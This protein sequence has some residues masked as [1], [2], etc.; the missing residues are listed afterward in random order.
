MGFPQLPK[1]LE[2]DGTTR[3][4]I[5]TGQMNRNLRSLDSRFGGL[6][7]QS[8]LASI[9]LL[10]TTPTNGHSYVIEAGTL[11]YTRFAGEWHT[12]PLHEFEIY[13]DIN[14]TSYFYWDGGA[15]NAFTF[16]GE[17]NTGSNLGGGAQVFKSKV[18][19]DL[20]HRTL[21]Q[22]SG[23]TL[24]QSANEIEIAATAGSVNYAISASGGVETTT[25]TAFQTYVTVDLTT[26]GGPVE[27]GMISDGS[28]NDA[29]LFHDANALNGSSIYRLAKTSGADIDHDYLLRNDV[30]A[31]GSNEQ[32]YVPSSCLKTIFTGLSAGSY[33]FAC[34]I[35]SSV[36]GVTTS[37]AY[38]KIYAREW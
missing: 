36:S 38:S 13:Y 32:V 9:A 5:Y 16:G 35:A 33:T 26:N 15:Y 14:L 34:E 4:S 21:T 25:G 20:Q 23:I 1:Q 29:R 8:R 3:F 22:G 31:G 6:V 19:V 28:G 17:V 37:I 27:V 2:G 30:D 24:T 18:G 12:T 11:V 10:P 7:V